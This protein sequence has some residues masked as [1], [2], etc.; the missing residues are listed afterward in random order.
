M[1]KVVKKTPEYTI[2]Q[3]RDGRYA[4]VG[5]NNKPVNGDEKVKVLLAEELIKVS[6]AAPAPVPEP[7]VEE[8]SAE[9][10]SAEENSS[11]DAKEA[12]E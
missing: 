2:S 3:R 5:S 6:V 10:A 1:M 12:S 4:V 7:E 9:E 8:A 11:D